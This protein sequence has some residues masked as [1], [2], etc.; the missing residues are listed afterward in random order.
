MRGTIEHHMLEKMRYA[1]NTRSLVDRADSIEDVETDERSAVHFMS[2]DL[3]PIG[4]FEMPSRE[5]LSGKAPSWSR[6]DDQKE[7]ERA[8]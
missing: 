1:R 8:P 5:R 4:E 2:V 7:K 6:K 3:K